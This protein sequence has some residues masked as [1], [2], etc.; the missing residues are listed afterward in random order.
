M[1]VPNSS[2]QKKECCG[3]S[4]ASRGEHVG[5]RVRLIDRVRLVLHALR[6]PGVRI[7]PARDIPDREHVGCRAPLG[8]AEHTVG[9]VQSAPAQPL[10]RGLAADR[11]DDQVGDELR[12][13]GEDQGGGATRLARF[14]DAGA[15]SQVDAV[16][17]EQILRTAADEPDGR[18]EADARAPS[19]ERHGEAGLARGRGQLASEHARSDDRH[20]GSGCERGTQRDDVVERADRAGRRDGVQS[21]R[22]DTGRDDQGLES[23]SRRDR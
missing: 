17:R 4:R 21:P 19:D 10:D 15:Q 8:I 1:R 12:A 2:V 13:V 3:C 18:T 22:H 20:P 16:G 11:H 6:D 9:Q 7:R 5:D 23:E 14:D